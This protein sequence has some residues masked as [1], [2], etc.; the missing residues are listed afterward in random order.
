MTQSDPDIE[1]YCGLMEEIK[2]RMNV[3]EF[4]IS[5]KGHALYEPPTIE[6]T[7]LQLRKILELIAFGS[8]VANKDSYSAVYAK[9]SKTWNAGDLLRELEDVNPEFYPAPVVQVASKIPGAFMEHKKRDPL[10]YLRR[11]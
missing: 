4:F 5:G 3:V 7:T 2:L 8:L 9:V 11:L 6:S 10:D 1:K